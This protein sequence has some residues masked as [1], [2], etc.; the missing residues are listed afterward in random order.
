MSMV[1]RLTRRAA[2]LAQ[3]GRRQEALEL[4]RAVIRMDPHYEAAWRLYVHTLST[5][6]ERTAAL[7]A[8]LRLE[9]DNRD[10]QETLWS[11]WKVE[12]SELRAQRD[13]LIR[14]LSL[15]AIALG[16]AFMVILGLVAGLVVRQE[17]MDRWRGRV[18]A[19][20]AEGEALHQ[21]H[22]RLLARFHE[23]QRA[24]N[25]LAAAHE[26]LSTDLDGLRARYAAL[27]RTHASLIEEHASLQAEYDSLSSE[28]SL[29]ASRLA[30]L[31]QQSG[32]PGEQGAGPEVNALV[33]PYIAVKGRKIQM[34][35]LRS[36]GTVGGWEAPFESLERS[37]EM[38]INKRAGALWDRDPVVNL[39]NPTTGETF[40]LWDYRAFVDPGPFEGVM[41]DLWAG[42]SS[43]YDLI[44]E[45]W[46]IVS[47]LTTYSEDIDE[48]PRYP[49]ETF[50]AGGGDCE[51]TSILLASMIKAAPVPWKVELVYMDIDHPTAPQ[52]V[53][54][55]IVHID[56]G[57]REYYIE[58]TSAD[59]ME[60]Y[61][62]ILAWHFEVEG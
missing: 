15:V 7:E 11:L 54:H 41:A 49:L 36:D 26:T 45:T 55:V 24:H 53:N 14:T 16:L 8:Y 34:V 28:H 5:A 32:T 18:V 40:S 17:A 58:T 38:G 42:T 23:L 50:L 12:R 30:D 46:H 43:D 33:P 47:Q 44:Y 21:A 1:S 37:I 52:D 3:A 4:L 35:F 22:D 61:G 6:E 48:T 9:P 29:L 20:E 59:I 62:D 2:K 60:P 25:D 56:T 13:R 39:E 19:L 27:Q 10:A 31:E 57:E 51:D